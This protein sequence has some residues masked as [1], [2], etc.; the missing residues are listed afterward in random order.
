[1]QS[2]T[3]RPDDSAQRV[4]VEHSA[5]RPI[6]ADIIYGGVDVWS[7]AIKQGLIDQS[8]DWAALGVPADHVTG[9]HMVRI[10]R[11]AA[12][13]TYNTE[14]LKASDLPDKWE[15]L[16]DPKWAGK[17]IVDPRGR[18]FDQLALDWGEAKVTDYV[19]QFK[20]VVKPVVVEGGTAGLVAVAGGQGLFTTGGR[21]AETEQQKQ[22]GA[23]HPNAAKCFMAWDA[24]DGAAFH[25]ETEVETNEDLPPGTPSGAKLLV[26]DTPDKADLVAFLLASEL[27]MDGTETPLEIERRVEVTD[28]LEEVRG[29]VAEWI[30]IVVDRADATAKS[31]GLPKVGMVAPPA[32]YTGSLGELIRAE[33]MDLSGRLMSMQTAHRSYMVTGAICTGAAARVEGTL[34]HQVARPPVPGRTACGSPT[35]TG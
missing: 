1:M 25:L 24:T 14:K 3:L 4:A 23:A 32:D 30:G 13:V 35:P 29:I 6:S 26:A 8:V 5:G 7:S 20:Q 31:P 19:R 11:V 16:V 33:D 2:T 27:G 9:S 17:V 28:A 18:P 15:D 22:K 12:G 21:S 34:V 10:F